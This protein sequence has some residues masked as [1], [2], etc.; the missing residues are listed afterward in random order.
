MS[1]VKIVYRCEYIL[2]APL[3]TPGT[4]KRCVRSNG[5]VEDFMYGFWIDDNYR[6]TKG[7]N[8]KYWIPPGNISYVSKDYIK[9]D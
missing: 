7:S 4:E 8:A 2:P 6:F 5:G 9:A 3:S 1:K